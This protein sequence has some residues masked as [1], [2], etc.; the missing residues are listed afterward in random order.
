M[1]VCDYL[2]L[3]ML[4]SGGILAAS[5]QVEGQTSA[6]QER[7]LDFSDHQPPHDGN[8]HD[9]SVA[10]TG[11]TARILTC[12]CEGHCPGNVQ[13]G[14]C[15]TRPGGSCFASVEA[16]MDDETKQLVP[17]WSHGC[18][19]PEQGG[20]LLQCKVGTVSPQLHG[21]SIVCCDNE[22]LCNQDLKPYYSLRTTT[23]TEPPLVNTNSIPLFA[24]I[25]SIVLCLAGLI[26]LIGG[27]YCVYR[28]REK[29]KPAYLM[30][31][32]YNTTNGHLPIA[33]LVEQTSGSGS[34]LPLL[35]QRTIAKQIQMVHSVGKGRY[36]EVW[37]AKWRDEKVA[38][39]IFF[40]TEEASWFRETEI[41]QTVLMRNENILGFIA[42]DI[43][44]TGSWT[45]MLL[46]TD[47]HEL[48]SLHDY[49]QK[50]VLNPHMLKTLAL[51][52]ASGVAHLHTEIFGTPGKP[53]IAH[54]DIKSKNILVKRNG[55]CAIADFGLAV[56]YTS[57]SDEIQIAP[58]SRVGTRRY[59]A[60]EVL[61]ETLDLKVFEGFKMADMYSVGL[62]FWEMA[63]RCITTV[64]GAKNTTTCE[65][66]ALP[67]QDVVPSDPSFED[68][69]A[70]VCV[71]GVRPPIPQR[72]QD[73]DILVVLSKIMQECWHPSPA[74]RLTALRVKK[75][76]VKLETDC[77]I[78][79]V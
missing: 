51:S 61:S 6:G 8:P 35:V 19:S 43:K 36:G 72:W 45:Q 28:R 71:K 32:L 17:E 22:D 78:K 53:S 52:L 49:L 68:M 59:M 64:R 11:S 79:I 9:P 63:R 66:Y 24:L 38:V 60:P 74:V 55:Q 75:T 76:L 57:E 34:G 40:T 12:Y 14:T 47:Y 26:L 42:A 7:P 23:T 15:E 13:N 18:M 30:N 5:D 16:V 50:R 2:V 20:G 4:F 46:I 1:R 65:D 62:V 69:Y 21:K 67:Y 31:S 73:E 29:R 58:N 33:D 10:A 48:G 70:V 27:I 56:K 77:T 25:I 41:Y 3:L 37:L 54:R 39:K 44:G